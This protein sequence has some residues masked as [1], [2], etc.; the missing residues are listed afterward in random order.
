LRSGA[1]RIFVLAPTLL[2]MA[3][4]PDEKVPFHSFHRGMTLGLF[5][6]PGPDH[7]RSALDELQA[8]GVNAISLV[9]PRTT[10]DVRS[11]S[12]GRRAD[13]TPSDAAVVEAI[14][15][16]RARGMRV[17]LLPILFV[18]HLEEGEWRGTLAPDDWDAW[19][20]RYEALILDYARMAQAEGVELFCVGSELVSSEHLEQHWRALIAKV[21]RIYQGGLFYSANWDHYQGIGFLDALDYSGVNAY[22]QLTEESRPTV[23]D[24]VQAWAPIRQALLAWSGAQGRPLLFTEVGYPSREGSA[25]DPW[26]HSSRRP[27]SAEE[28]RRCYRAFVEAWRDV[29][30]LSG[31]F[32]Y[33]W[34]G[35]GGVEDRDYTPRNKPAARE[36]AGWFGGADPAKE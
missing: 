35:D 13:V 20:Q 8:L 6:S 32:F 33:L 5:F 30:E 22:Y 24:L 28:Q 4:A 36:L 21:R 15:Q 9:V 16:A 7:I 18:E 25:I 2:L 3:C 12:F 29:N 11:A 26:N 23:Q 27:A 1:L 31:V 17:M 10:P 14:R 19:F 34:W